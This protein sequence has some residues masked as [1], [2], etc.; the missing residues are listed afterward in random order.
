M[1]RLLKELSISEVSSVDRGAGHGVRIMLMKRDNPGETTMDVIQKAQQMGERQMV[2]FCK[3]DAITKAQLGILIDDLAQAKR[4]GGESREQAFTKFITEDPLG[5][6]L[7]KVHQSSAGLDHHQVATVDAIAKAAS[8]KAPPAK[9]DNSVAM[10]EIERLAQA[11][12]KENPKQGLT[13]EQARTHVMTQTEKGK[14][15]YA[16][17]RDGYQ[18]RMH[19]AQY[20]P[21]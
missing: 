12:I 4:A 2:E 20:A 14:Q 18:K 10:D 6:D 16:Q 19:V 9:G 8:G 17:A 3:T 1:P 15:L 11:H 5:R 7:F 21:A 13:I